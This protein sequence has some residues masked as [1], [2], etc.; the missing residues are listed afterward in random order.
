[1]RF[2]PLLLLFSSVLAQY[3]IPSGYTNTF[4][5]H[6]QFAAPGETNSQTQTVLQYTFGTNGQTSSATL[7]PPADTSFTAVSFTLQ[8]TAKG[9]QFDRLI[10]ISLTTN[11]AG[12]YVEVWR[13]STF[14]PTS[15]GVYSTYTKDM[16]GFISLLKSSQVLSMN[17]DNYVD[18]TYT[19]QFAV[20]VSQLAGGISLIFAVVKIFGDN[21]DVV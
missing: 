7:T 2:T 18:S 10:H 9:T 6:S 15:N 13:S 3:T 12:N 5:L 21:F 8:N 1:M 20:Q 17:M 4:Q 11:G 19:G 16:T 14:E